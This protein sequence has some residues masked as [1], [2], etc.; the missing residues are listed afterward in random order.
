MT[1][2]RALLTGATGFVGGHTARALLAE[3]WAV[4]ALVRSDPSRSP[5]LAGLPA[6]F[7]R[8]DLSE[9]ADLDSIVRDCQAIVHVAG[10]VKARTLE[11]YREVNVRGTERLAAAAA[12]AAAEAVFVLV[13]SQ[14]AAGPA[15][16]GRPVAASDPARPVSWYGM[17]KLE[18]EA[19]LRGTFPGPTIVLRPGVVYGPA[20]TGLLTFF[21]MAAKGL[22]AVPGGARRIQIVAA[23]R[24]ARAIARAAGRPGLAGAMAFV[25][26]PAPIAIRAL[27]G[28]IAAIPAR[29]ARMVPVPDLVVRAAGAAETLR[30]AITKRS[31][32]FNADKARELLAGEW[33]CEA[34]FE[35]EL[36]LPPPV[37]LENGLRGAWDWYVRQGWLTL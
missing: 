11:D 5:L 17:S 30:E 27:A 3:G 14:A 28:M 4:R 21:R 16:G 23:D 25:C 34:G 37:P 29:R 32:P 24:A 20:D 22:V 12:R 2:R 19:A 8:G 15:R 31:R 6:E 35:A 9:A 18:G 36:G 13:S 1:T 33:L 7:V 10:L 26:D